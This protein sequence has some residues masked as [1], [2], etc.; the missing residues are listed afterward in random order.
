MDA[1]TM[2]KIDEAWNAYFYPGTNVLKNKL[3]ITDYDELH[4]KEA[5]ITFEKLV[6][7]QENPIKGTFNKEHLFAIHKYLFDDLYEWAGQVRTVDMQKKEM[8]LNYNRIND[9]LDEEL[10]MMNEEVNN[11]ISANSLAYFLTRYFSELLF[12]HP[13]REG[14]G[15]SIREF[16]SQFVLE[17]TPS[18][19]CGPM[20]IDWSLMDSEGMLENIDMIRVFPGFY[21]IQF[22]KGLVKCEEEKTHSH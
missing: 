15:R 12:I 7:L 3:G 2:R 11:V 6:E 10:R 17:K 22:M 1:D 5:E 14:N 21:E 16:L 20:E 19:P 4:R 8:F 13:F 9:F 18:L